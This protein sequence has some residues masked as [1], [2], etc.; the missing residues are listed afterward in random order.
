MQVKSLFR[1][2]YLADQFGYRNPQFR[3]LQNRYDLFA[4]KSPLPH[5]KT[6]LFAGRDPA[7]N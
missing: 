3:Q 7:S 1:D 5:G 6:L 4:R 2:A